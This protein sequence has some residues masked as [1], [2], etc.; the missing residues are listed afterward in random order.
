MNPFLFFIPWLV[1]LIG[2]I[3]LMAQG[4]ALNNENSGYSKDPKYKKHPEMNDVKKDDKLMYVR[5]EKT[6]EDKD[7]D[8]LKKRID[9]LK[10]GGISK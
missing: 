3:F 10:D 5:F 6:E 8:I 1:I 2:A 9:E 4:W 7:Y